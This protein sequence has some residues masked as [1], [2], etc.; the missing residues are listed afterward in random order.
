MSSGSECYPVFGNYL[1]I[2]HRISP[3]SMKKK[4]RSRYPL[5]IDNTL[6][7][8]LSKWNKP[9]RS[10]SSSANVQ[11]HM[12]T[13]FKRLLVELDEFSFIYITRSTFTRPPESGFSQRQMSRSVERRSLTVQAKI[14]VS[15]RPN[16]NS[17]LSL[18]E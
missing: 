13:T 15:S 6:F 18:L 12:W 2:I 7:T 3:V 11:G 9:M 17:E 8:I 1:F 16:L 14:F 4:Y 10:S 5:S